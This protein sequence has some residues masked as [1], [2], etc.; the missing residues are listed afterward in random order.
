ML[1]HHAENPPERLRLFIGRKSGAKA[2]SRWPLDSKNWQPE[3][4]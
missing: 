2:Y 4:N 1:E 3:L